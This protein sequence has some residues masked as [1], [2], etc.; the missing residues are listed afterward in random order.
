MPQQSLPLPHKLSLNDRKILTVTGV[1]EV[2]SFDE[3]SV[4]LATC[5]GELTVEGENLKLK[6]MSAELGQATIEGTVSGLYY[7]ESRPAVSLWRRV[8]G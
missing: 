1:T 7:E 6:N 8:F 2:G 4:T 3:N 5:Q